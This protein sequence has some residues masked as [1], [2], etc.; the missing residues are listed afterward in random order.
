VS[1]ECEW[2]VASGGECEW[3]VASGGEWWG[4]RI[5]DVTQSAACRHVYWNRGR[6][7]HVRRQQAGRLGQCATGDRRQGRVLGLGPRG[8]R[9]DAA[10]T[11]G[12]VSEQR[13]FIKP[14]KKRGCTAAQ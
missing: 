7:R 6:G 5:A 4:L 2:S 12:A 14:W 3:S 13:R 8:T 11:A 1:G 10:G 9:R